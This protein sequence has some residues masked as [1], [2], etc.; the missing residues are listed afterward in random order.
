M[1]TVL[2]APSH[3]GVK[4]TRYILD[5]ISRLKKEGISLELILVEGLSHSEVKQVYERA[6]LLIDQL[7]CGWYGGVAIELMA[8]G[9]PVICYIRKEDLKFIPEKMRQELPII[10]ATPATVYTVLKEWLTVR[11]HELL[12]VGRRSRAYVERWHDPL[13]IAAKLKGEYEAIMS[14]KQRDVTH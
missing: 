14:S 1:P 11:K 7:L 8:L 10:N 4:G 3:R 5:A 6:D 13:K 12:E 9:K 2:H